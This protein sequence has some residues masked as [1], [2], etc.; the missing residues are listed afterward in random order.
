MLY[1]LSYKRRQQNSFCLEVGG[2]GGSSRGGGTPNNVYT[3][4]Y[5][6]K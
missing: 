4:K 2:F 1:V 3:H 6:Q 5:M